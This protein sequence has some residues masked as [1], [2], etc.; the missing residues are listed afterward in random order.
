MHAERAFSNFLGEKLNAKPENVEIG[1]VYKAFENQ[2]DTPAQQRQTESLVGSL[3]LEDSR[4]KHTCSRFAASGIFYHELSRLYQ[5][6]SK[7]KISAAFQTQTL[8]KIVEKMN[9][10]ALQKKTF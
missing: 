2:F 3:T 7:I 4:K 10:P 5:Q 6:F 9:G 1:A 8:L